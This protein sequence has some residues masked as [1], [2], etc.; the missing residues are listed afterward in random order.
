MA[1]QPDLISQ[2]A[3]KIGRDL[4]A[5]GHRDVRVHAITRVSLNGRAPQ[6]LI[7]PTVDLMKVRD[8][9]SR[10][11]VTPEPTDSPP[12]VLPLH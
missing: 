9:G 2:L 6:A 12:I 8:V 7:D 4:I 10:D 3:R 11:W 5:R 1:G